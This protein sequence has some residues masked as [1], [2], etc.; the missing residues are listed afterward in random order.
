LENRCPL[1]HLIEKIGQAYTNENIEH[2]MQSFGFSESTNSF[3]ADQIFDSCCQEAI[4]M[5]RR[6]EINSSSLRPCLKIWQEMGPKFI[7][8]GERV[9]YFLYVISKEF[10]DDLNLQKSAAEEYLKSL[11]VLSDKLFQQANRTKDIK[12]LL[13]ARGVAYQA[14]KVIESVSGYSID[15]PLHSELLLAM[16]STYLVRG[17][18]DHFQPVESLE[19]Y[20]KA[21]DLKKQLRHQKPEDFNRLKDNIRRIIDDLILVKG[22]APEIFG[23]GVAIRELEIAYS[24]SKKLDDANLHYKIVM[25]LSDLYSKTGRPDKAEKILKETL[26]I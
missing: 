5:I 3:N 11:W 23:L 14:L 26:S 21:L 16:G 10:A 15:L 20:S 12:S 24:T 22:V 2:L 7:H 6:G 4:N 17:I 19:Y 25:T 1:D 18:Q 8:I 13:N 9:A